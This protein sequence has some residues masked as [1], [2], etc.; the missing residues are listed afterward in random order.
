MLNLH[1]IFKENNKTKQGETFTSVIASIQGVVV[2][3]V[4]AAMVVY[5]LKNGGF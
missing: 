3:V 5:V 4:V 1:K 2:F